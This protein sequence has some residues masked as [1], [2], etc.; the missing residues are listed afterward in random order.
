MGSTPVHRKSLETGRAEILP[1]G[2]K[3]TLSNLQHRLDWMRCFKEP[4]SI[5]ARVMHSS[6]GIRGSGDQDLT[7]VQNICQ[8]IKLPGG[9]VAKA[10]TKMSEGID[11]C[12]QA[13]SLPIGHSTMDLCMERRNRPAVLGVCWLLTRF[14]DI[15]TRRQETLRLPMN[16]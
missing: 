8:C 2:L 5:T 10:A 7:S 4:S 6:K 9:I 11:F 12:F 13:V 14:E 1:P 15:T 16:I 3:D